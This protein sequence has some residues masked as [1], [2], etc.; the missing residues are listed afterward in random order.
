MVLIT[1][2]VTNVLFGIVVDKLVNC[3]RPVS[4]ASALFTKT[5]MMTIFLVINSIGVPVLIYADIFGFQPT[6]YVSLL[7]IIS[8]D[9][10][11]FLRV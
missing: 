4:K 7:T 2:A 10:K 9:I 1:S 5:T 8:T 3:V 11:N 6:S